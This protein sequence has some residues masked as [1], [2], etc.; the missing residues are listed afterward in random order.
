MEFSNEA[1][2]TYLYDPL[3]LG[4]QFLEEMEHAMAL[5]NR[6][7]TNAVSL[8]LFHIARG[9]IVELALIWTPLAQLLAISIHFSLRFHPLRLIFDCLCI[10]CNVSCCLVYLLQF[11]L[12]TYAYY[13]C[14]GWKR[15]MFEITRFDIFSHITSVWNRTKRTETLWQRSNI[16]ACKRQH[17]FVPLPVCI[18]CALYHC[19]CCFVFSLSSFLSYVVNGAWSLFLFY[20]GAYFDSFAGL[21]VL[22]PW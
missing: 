5:F 9:T 8:P 2:F 17:P 20:P 3:I 21:I 16:F 14:D 15:I 19:R 7:P 22:V 10:V 4:K 1:F 6:S 18:L 13:P 12:D 11:N